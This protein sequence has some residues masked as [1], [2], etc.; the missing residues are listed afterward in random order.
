MDFREGGSETESGGP[1][2]GPVH[3]FKAHYYDIVPN[4]RIVYSYE[5][6]LDEARTSVSVATVQ[7]EADDG[8]T[9]LALTE[10]GAYLDGFDNPGQREA[11]TKELLDSLGASL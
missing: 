1:R 9:H 11:G 10:Q 4:Q 5:M 6:Y 7:L 2:G 8:G 3:H